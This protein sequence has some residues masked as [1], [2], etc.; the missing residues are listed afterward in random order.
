[1]N[2]RL[3]G[4]TSSAFIFA[5]ALTGC[6]ISSGDSSFSFSITNDDEEPNSDKSIETENG[7]KS[8]KKVDRGEL[9][10]I[11]DYMGSYTCNGYGSWGGDKYPD[12]ETIQSELEKDPMTISEDGTMHFHGSDYKLI[13]EGTIDNTVVFSI[14]GSGFNFDKYPYHDITDKDYEGAVYF[15]KETQQMTVNDVDC[16]YVTY[17]V[18]LTAKDDTSSSAYISFNKD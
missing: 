10:D 11:K 2:K 5:A 7:K 3:L 16:P 9:P 8:G 18:C 1:M 12:C 15:T 14:D 4:L 13:P 6:T 17:K